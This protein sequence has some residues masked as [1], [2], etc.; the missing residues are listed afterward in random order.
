MNSDDFPFPSPPQ[1]VPSGDSGH[2]AARDRGGM[3]NKDQ[4]PSRLAFLLMFILLAAAIVITGWLY[5]RNFQRQFRAAIE[6]NLSVIADLKVRDLARYREERL[7]DG[8]IFFQNAPFAALVRRFLEKP[9]DADAQRQIQ[10]WLGKYQPYYDRVLLLDV[11]GAPRLS[12]PAGLPPL[13]AP[14]AR[15]VAEVLRSGRVTI[16]DFYRSEQ[17]QRVHL[18]VLTPIFDERDTG[19]PWGWF[20]C[21]LIPKLIFTPSSRAGRRPAGPPKHCSSAGKA[22][23]PSS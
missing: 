23:R 22:T 7:E 17:D 2:E 12:S 5:Y 11:Q 4:D 13:S 16:Q 21:A 18:G 3:K 15:D 1:P 8:S 14:V 9:D 20:I 10:V 6:Q 19:R